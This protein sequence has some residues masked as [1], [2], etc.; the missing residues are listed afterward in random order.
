M[1]VSR[2]SLQSPDGA[3][4]GQADDIHNK[5]LSQKTG[6]PEEKADDI[7]NKELSQ[8]TGQPE[9]K[10]SDSDSDLYG[11][12]IEKNSKAID[13]KKGIEELQANDEMLINIKE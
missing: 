6:Q 4:R 7:H 12:D 8:K 10:G 5:E 9:E 11:S 13:A 2:V 3:A 1:P